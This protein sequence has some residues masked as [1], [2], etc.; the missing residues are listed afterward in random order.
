MAVDL[1]VG[2][3][4]LQPAVPGVTHINGSYGLRFSFGADPKEL[5]ID[6]WLFF[7]RPVSEKFKSIYVK[8]ISSIF[9]DSQKETKIARLSKN[10]EFYVFAEFCGL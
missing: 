4:G 6:D 1:G 2:E 3:S 5:V 8:R 7:L 10:P 9:W